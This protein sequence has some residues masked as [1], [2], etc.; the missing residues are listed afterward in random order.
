M[1]KLSME[2]RLLLAFLLMGVV[3]VISNYLMPPQQPAE[4]AKQAAPKAAAPAQGQ[5]QAQTAPA[6]AAAAAE[7]P[8][9]VQAAEVETFA[10]DTDLFKVAFSNR[11][12]T[13]H[14]WVLK[15]YKSN[16]GKDLELVNQKAVTGDKALAAPFALAFKNPPS[17][18]PNDKLY[19]VTDRKSTRLNSSH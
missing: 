8:G 13:I 19:K 15:K 4:Q 7:V 18:D 10:I 2:V 1:Q 3:M 9:A 17:N 16:A 6:A 11:G 5:A 12:A 14:N